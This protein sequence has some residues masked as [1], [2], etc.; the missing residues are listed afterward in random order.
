M[1]RPESSFLVWLDCRSLGSSP[2][3]LKEL[4]LNKARVALTWGETY[5]PDGEGFER[6]YIACPRATLEEAMKRIQGVI[7]G[8][9][10]GSK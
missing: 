1:I 7:C 10:R 4:F 6:I 5:G 3:G 2:Q 9:K 8:M